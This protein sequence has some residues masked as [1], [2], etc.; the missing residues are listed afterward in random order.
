MSAAHPAVLPWLALILLIAW[1]VVRRVRRMVGRQKLSAVRPWVTVVLFPTLAVLLALA[2]LVHPERLAWLA[3][4]LAAGAALGVWGM[5]LTRF[6]STPQG[7]Y[8]TP[9]L[10][11]GIALSLLLIGRVLF[12]FVQVLSIADAMP[13]AAMT[14][15]GGPEF[16]R[17]P[18]TLGIFGLLAGYYTAYAVGLLRR[19]SSLPQSPAQPTPRNS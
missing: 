19:R 17:S 18:S 7:V 16:V 8:Y 3:T 13:G 12:R 4:G 6:E 15:F 11:L 2:A 14:S 9:N 10:H 1:R 5:N